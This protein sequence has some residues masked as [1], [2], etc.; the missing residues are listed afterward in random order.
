MPDR[1]RLRLTLACGN[2]DIN[3]A[4]LDGSISPEG[5][6]LISLAM[7]SPERHWRMLRSQEFDICELSMA[8][9]LLL[10]DRRSYPFVAIP[11]FPHRRFRH[12]YIFVNAS[13]GI[14]APQ[15][16]DGRTIGIRNWQ[17]TAGLWIRGIL[18]ERY[19]VDLSRIQWLSQDEEDIP[20][21]LPPR[22]QMRQL[23]PGQNLSQMIV[24]GE[25]EALVYPEIPTSFKLGDPRV[26]RLFERPKDEEQAYFRETGLFPIMHTVVVKEAVLEKHAWVAQ[27]MLKAFRASKELAFQQM[28]NPRR[29]S[30]AWVRELVEEE[31]RVLGA[32]PWPYN[33]PDN[34]VALETMVRY[35]QSQG[36]MRREL[37]VEDLFFTPALEE[38]PVYV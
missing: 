7:P 22:F 15:D 17:N 5:I 4:L 13:S 33:L 10:R 23:Q 27:A 21:D 1:N 6:D 38:M 32:D 18:E 16:L 37:A 25:V 28:E 11:V 30:L 3:A 14:R 12:G 35:A 8:S 31:R 36:L 9:Y 19:G 2:Y 24:G 34:R 20:F 29:I 26:R